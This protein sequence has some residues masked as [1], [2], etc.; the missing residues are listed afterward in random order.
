MRTLDKPAG[1]PVFPPHDDPDGDCVLRRLLGDDPARGALA[2]PAGFEGG[3][4]HRLDTSTSGA[5]LVADD[6]DE[7]ARL[8]AAFASARLRKTY[9]LLAARDVPWDAHTV[10]RPLAHDRRHKR[11]MI[12]Q[13]GASTPHRGDWYPAHTELRRVRGRLWEAVI[14]TGVMHQIRAHA[15]FVGLP[16]VGDRLYGGGPTPDDA[17]PGVTFFLHH[18]G[19]QGDGVATDPVPL[20]AWAR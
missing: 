15:A 20:P 7:L 13:R 12:V 5:L 16:L 3:L 18:V 1:L 9:R 2:W 17:P 8:R 11:R 6:P 10:D 4:A 14:T 19:L